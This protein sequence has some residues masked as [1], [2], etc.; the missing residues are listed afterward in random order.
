MCFCLL[1][2][3]QQIA[4]L[5]K[6]TA[7]LKSSLLITNSETYSLCYYAATL[8]YAFNNEL[9]SYNMFSVK[10]IIESI[11]LKWFE[12]GRADFT[13]AICLMNNEDSHEN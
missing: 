6:A 10:H 3:Q 12:G 9:H 7:T 4:K 11:L 1:Y 2:V 5:N 8:T 13:N